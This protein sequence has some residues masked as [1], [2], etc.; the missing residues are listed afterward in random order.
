MLAS[1]AAIAGVT[2]S[3]TVYNDIDGQAMGGIN[4]LSAYTT[5]A[6]NVLLVNS[7]GII[8]QS[9]AVSGTGAYTFTNVAA[10]ADTIRLST[11]GTLNNA[12][13]AASAPGGYGFTGEGTTSAG[14]GMPDG[15]V[16]LTVASANLTVNFGIEQ[17][18][19]SAVSVLGFQANPGGTTNYTIP[20][21]SF[22]TS[23]VPATNPNTQDYGG[24]TVSSI[25]ITAFPTSATSLTING[26][27]PYT[28]ATFPAAGV[29]IPWNSGT[30]QP[31]Q[32]IQID[33]VDGNL[34]SIIH[35]AAIDNA[36]L[37]DPTP[38][39][40]Q[41]PFNGTSTVSGHVYND[42]NNNL[43]YNAGEGLNNV[44]VWLF[45]NNAGAP[46]YL[47]FPEDS[48]RTDVNGAYTFSNVATG[49]YQ[50]RVRFSTVPTTVP[51]PRTVID[52]NTYTADALPNSLTNLVMTGATTSYTNLDFGLAANTAAP[53][54]TTNQRFSFNP[55]A[56]FNAGQ[57]NQLS[58]TYNLAPQT[59][60][61][62]TYTPTITWK[63]DRN[64]QP[65]GYTNQYPQAAYGAGEFGAFFPG[66]SKGGLHPG[67][68]TYVV[69]AGDYG[70]YDVYP[71]NNNRTTTGIKFST[72]VANA[73]FTV[74]DVDNADPMRPGG[75]ID[76]VRVLGFLKG[77]AVTAPVITNPS[78][79]PWNTVYQNTI[80]GWPDYDPGN[81]GSY[82]NSGNVD[83]AADN[84][85]FSTTVD[86]IAVEYEEW[87]PVL[88]GTKGVLDGQ[89]DTESSWVTRV[90]EGRGISL[91]SVDYTALT[92][93]GNV[94]NDVNGLTDNLI[95]GTVPS[96]YG[97]LFANLVNNSG[98]V[99][100]TSP[101]AADG[102]YI[103]GVYPGAYTVKI[104]TSATT[105]SAT[106]PAGWVN[107]GEALASNTTATTGDGAPDGSLAVT[108]VNATITNADFGIERAPE[109]AI[110]AIGTQPNPGGS[111]IYTIAPGAFQTST[112]PATNPSTTDY[113]GGTVTDIR[114]TSFPATITS[115]RI[116]D[117]AYYATAA[118][119]P[120][121]CPTSVCLAFP[122]AGVITAYT[123]SAGP[124]QTISVDPIDGNQTVVLPFAAIDNAKGEDQTPGNVTIP[125]SVI[126]VAGNVF[127]DA[128]SSRTKN[129]V[130]QYV[131]GTNA[132]SGGSIVTGGN[133]FAN[134][135][136]A[137]GNVIATT[138]IA[139]DGS[140]TFANVPASTVGLKIQLSTVQGTIDAA[141][142][143]TTPP[144]GWVTTGQSIGSG[145]T[146]TPTYAP[147]VINLT[148][149]AANITAQ[150]FGIEWLS[151][152]DAKSYN[153]SG[154]AFSNTP[155]AGYPA[156]SN[157]LSIPSNSSALTGY[158]AGGSLTASDPEDCSTASSCNGTTGTT[159]SIETINA[160]TQLYYNF[161]GATGIAAVT[162]G[163][164]ISNFNPANLV[165][166]GQKGTGTA[167]SPVGFTYSMIDAAGEKGTAAT[168]AIISSTPLPVVLLSFGAAAAGNNVLASWKTGVEQNVSYY[169]VTRSTDAIHFMSL[170]KVTANGSNS[171]YSF[172]DAGAPQGLLY[173][174]LGI[175][176]ISGEI[177]QSGVV[178]VRVNTD[179]ANNI[180]VYP[181]PASGE[182]TVSGISAPARMELRNMLGQIM[183]Q[184][185]T[186][187]TTE[188]LNL[189]KIPSG[190]YLLNI[191]E[192]G[193]FTQQIKI[194]KN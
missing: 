148:T 134:L 51:T 180:I 124:A 82:F 138:Q 77:T 163:T 193:G 133:L 144:A 44:T 25:R 135:I 158:T 21:A 20:G 58:G 90:P 137:A 36:G 76:H 24:G 103:F 171:K 154:T 166:Y 84:V 81:P 147:G 61:A 139:A 33:P 97:S 92:L 121:T 151:T 53:A 50:I 186:E 74:Y 40:V 187:K 94:Y 52:N 106:L 100:A 95:N 150:N 6:L 105:S 174:R 127:D 19:E 60:G 157:Y 75:R 28:A 69:I 116:H 165:I 173:Y 167:A 184:M 7:A 16:V 170:G 48:V 15:N 56:T 118:A 70:D 73:K 130:E 145:N 49:N 178:T 34:T 113:D 96:I 101:V 80:T 131:S 31:A 156:V 128:D 32:T 86:S 13:P 122:A 2:I 3:G 188:H 10:S 91:G 62:S 22:A 141:Q 132:S 66:M 161:G 119:I 83:N 8:L 160:N 110:T 79:T 123:N 30:N 114:F 140:Y 112:T 179:N 87:A 63:Q 115:L 194:S 111:N 57:N 172:T 14:D 29:V 93:S 142:P 55:N 155:P 185:S 9:A 4:N 109:S 68:T 78:A 11:G 169:T 67:D 126:S 85:Y 41:V 177:T 136:N 175:T 27:T 43:A 46:N 149:A 153:V 183:L 104:T 164:K 38:G 18:P 17:T 26:G 152:A 129:G 59:F 182:L 54:F 159:Y 176:G 5:G 37:P 146:A 65:P 162:A 181:N 42:A 168:Y 23:A 191:T 98:V 192:D 72:P 35:F 107:V 64:T 39:S 71:T 102:S 120:G 117:T 45:N 88:M 189:G 89:R 125:F 143:A 108:V 12:A 1:I 99:V 47:V 190:T